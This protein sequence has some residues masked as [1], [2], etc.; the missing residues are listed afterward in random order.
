MVC[1]ELASQ[2]LMVLSSDPLAMR[3]PSLLNATEE[4]R[5]LWPSRVLMVCP[6]LASQILMVLSSDPLAMRLPSLLNATDS[7]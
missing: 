6:E 3:L 2:I 4:T 1:P 5:L 7:T